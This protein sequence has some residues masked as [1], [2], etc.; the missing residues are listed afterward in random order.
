MQL[1]INWRRMRGLLEA[2]AEVPFSGVSILRA[3]EEGGHNQKFY[4]WIFDCHGFFHNVALI[5]SSAM[6]VLYLAFQAKKSFAKLSNG[7]SYIM[8]AYY[9]FVW[10]VSL[11]NLAWCSLQVWV[12]TCLNEILCRCFLFCVIDLSNSK[13]TQYLYKLF[14]QTVVT[15]IR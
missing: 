1:D 12:L 3:E 8:I 14:I 5:V 9:G 13:C 6:F 2:I 11:L 15:S 10:L 4:N 7:R